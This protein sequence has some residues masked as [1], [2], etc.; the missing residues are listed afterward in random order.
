MGIS[1][2]CLEFSLFKEL[3]AIA[4]GW[5]L[6]ATLLSSYREVELL[7]PRLDMA[8]IQQPTSRWYV[9]W[10]RGYVSTNEVAVVVVAVEI[11][12]GL[13]LRETR[14]MRKGG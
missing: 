14:P 7:G 3:S 8:G 9:L 1:A 5:L 12:C 13:P 10:W 6:V 11:C 2:F 4:E